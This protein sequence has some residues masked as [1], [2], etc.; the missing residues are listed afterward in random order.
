MLV[1]GLDR[2]GDAP[3]ALAPVARVEPVPAREEPVR[4]SYGR[5]RA[6]AA[7]GPDG[8]DRYLDRVSRRHFPVLDKNPLAAGGNS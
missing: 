4:P 6:A 2:P 5:L 8:L 1:L 7:E 3:A